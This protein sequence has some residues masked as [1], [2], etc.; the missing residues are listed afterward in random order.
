MS[1]NLN[2]IQFLQH[3][4]RKFL[5]SKKNINNKK[6]FNRPP[7]NKS[8]N[9][10][11]YLNS[12]TDNY[13]LNDIE[14]N[15]N[16]NSAEKLNNSP[17]DENENK[18]IETQDEIEK[19]KLN[20]QENN[21]SFM[22]NEIKYVENLRIQNAVYTGELLNGKRHGKGL[23]IWDDGAKYEGEWENDKS[24]GYGTF[25]HTD[26]DIYQGYWKNNRANGKGVR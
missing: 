17:S 22:N 19:F 23:Q 5:L 2:Q 11:L 16:P 1:K 12:T 3:Q 21:D 8:K 20:N 26:G 4:I 18:E 25:Y 15:N 9:N 10:Y 13:N 6:I 14:T 24:N 7:Q